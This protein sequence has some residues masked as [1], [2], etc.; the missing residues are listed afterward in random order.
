MII[1]LP[2]FIQIPENARYVYELLDPRTKEV[3]YVGQTNNLKH[4]Y[5]CHNGKNELNRNTYKSRWIKSLHK[6]GLKPIMR[7]VCI[8]TPENI[9]NTEIRTI[10]SHTNLTNATAG[11]EGIYK[12]SEETKKK[13]SQNRKGKG[14]GRKGPAS[15]EHVRPVI[16]KNIDSGVEI[17][18]SSMSEA[19]RYF[20][21][22]SGNIWK[23]INGYKKQIKNHTWSD[24]N[25]NTKI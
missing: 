15:K 24:L 13:I 23:A 6:L 19:A 16:A 21:I 17:C 20:G 22:H 2:D 18:F 5:R 10:A 8:T 11:G 3:R 14:L 7:V 25:G 9:N 4:R 1:K 12:C